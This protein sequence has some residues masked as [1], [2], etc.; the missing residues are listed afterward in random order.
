MRTNSV[1]T[2]F[3]LDNKNGKYKNIGSY[4]AWVYRSQR[5]RN[6]G[7]GARACDSITIRIAASPALK[8]CAGDLIFFGKTE[9]ESPVIAECKRIAKVTENMVGLMPHWCIEAE[10]E[11][12]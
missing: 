4:P 9:M 1:I 5:I 10:N 7:N 2:L 12:R 3:G 11:Y 6:R 8:I